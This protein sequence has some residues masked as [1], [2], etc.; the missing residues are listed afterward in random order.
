MNKTEHFSQL[1]HVTACFR[2]NVFSSTY[3]FYLHLYKLS[4]THAA[5]QS[6][7]L[8]SFRPK[9]QYLS[10][11]MLHLLKSQTMTNKF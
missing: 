7:E 1:D 3:V 11:P 4:Q 9:S 5:L 10:L 2:G 6:S 8:S